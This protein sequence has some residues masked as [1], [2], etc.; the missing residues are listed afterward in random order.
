MSLDW[1][2]ILK[3]LAKRERQRRAVIS[4]S[5]QP[6]HRTIIN[7]GV[8][9]G[10]SYTKVCYRDLGRERSGIVAFAG[11][12]RDDALIRSC[13]LV[14]STGACETALTSAELT[15]RQR[16][17][18]KV[19]DY[20]KIRL[21]E[22]DVTS[23]GQWR[24]PSLPELTTPE[25]TEACCAYFLA[26]TLRRAKDWVGELKD[27]ALAHR[28]VRWSAN[29]GVPVEH[30]DSAALPRF[31]RVLTA[32]WRMAGS[33]DRL[34]ERMEQIV[35]W[36]RAASSTEAAN[37]DCH[38]FPEVVAAVTSFTAARDARPGIYLYFDIGAGT[39]DGVSF[40]LYRDSGQ[41]RIVSHCGRVTLHG[42]E[43]IAAR[44]ARG[45]PNIAAEAAELLVRAPKLPWEL[46]EERGAIRRLVADVV[47]R[48]KTID[49]WS[50]REF[51]D[52]SRVTEAHWIVRP[53]FDRNL[54]VLLGG[55]GLDSAFY[56]NAILETYAKHQHERCG[57]PPYA[58]AR[59]P[60]PSDLELNGLSE[61]DF[62]RFA[63]AYGLSIPQGEQSDFT[64]P[65]MIEPLPPRRPRGRSDSISYEDS[66]DAYD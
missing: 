20:L 10:T 61:L 38:A 6:I 66:R 13:I 49:G 32:A 22:L 24:F 23:S 18:S 5:D 39:V 29:V 2:R 62:P 21:A 54:I 57:I 17:G 56:Q 47:M 30:L 9:F 33:K 48:S 37:S 55:G 60:R 28:E 63:I 45:N 16:L 53:H 11:H 40:R 50:A 27:E 44:I 46:H 12:K 26:S 52:R 4:S 7:L 34:P 58:L 65:T 19:L 15:A 3:P 59:V 41:A 31:R 64:L 1:L 25:E 35:P 14:H 51:Q 43:A 42:V 8:D 36:W